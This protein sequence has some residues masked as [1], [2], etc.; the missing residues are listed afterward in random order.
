MSFVCD[1]ML[2]TDPTRGRHMPRT[3]QR[4]GFILASLQD[5]TL[6][7]GLL[8]KRG[9]IDLVLH[10]G[11]ACEDSAAHSALPTPHPDN[12]GVGQ[13]WEGS[14]KISKSPRIR[15]FGYASLFQWEGPRL[16]VHGAEA[17]C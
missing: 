13:Y 9:D 6:G 17:V 8:L 15:R 7:R 12:I 1:Q 14:D 3:P 11:T 4:V 2:M 5:H 16:P 10:E